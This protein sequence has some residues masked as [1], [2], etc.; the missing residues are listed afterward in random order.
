MTEFE[1][2][3]RLNTM[4]EAQ[5]EAMELQVERE[6]ADAV[7]SI[8]DRLAL[9]ATIPL[10]LAGAVVWGWVVVPRAALDAGIALVDLLPFTVQLLGMSGVLLIATA[11]A[12]LLVRAWARVLLQ[13]RP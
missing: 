8:S 6:R 13:R 3:A 2:M 4:S 5:R 1:S 9:V 12:V 11:G 7:A 10:W